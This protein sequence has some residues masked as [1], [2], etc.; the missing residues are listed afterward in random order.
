MHRMHEPLQFFTRSARS[1]A[2]GLLALALGVQ[3]VAADDDGERAALAGIVHE[4]E[5]LE[6]LIRE[7]QSQS[8]PDARIRLR[9]DWLRQDLS[10]IR[11]GIRA[12]IDVPRAEPRSFPPLRGDYRR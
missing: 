10:R 11:R 3:V 1:L 5:A 6:P 2:A 8:R 7:A 12:H 9:Y 4:L